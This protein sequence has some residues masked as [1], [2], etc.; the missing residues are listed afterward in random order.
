M[1]LNS[2][3]QFSCKC[4]YCC[5]LVSRLLA[6]RA[7]AALAHM[8]PAC[9]LAV[10]LPVCVVH[11]Q[12]VLVWLSINSWIELAVEHLWP[13]GRLALYSNGSPQP[14]APKQRER[15]HALSRS[16][17]WF[18]YHR[19][20]VPSALQSHVSC[21][22]VLICLCAAHCIGTLRMNSCISSLPLLQMPRTR[23]SRTGHPSLQRSCW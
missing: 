3:D 11:H 22:P 20:A 2:K 23:W 16:G 13:V 17:L 21:V 14:T 9:L 1:E 8:F 15:M 4:H 19:W 7:A 6:D 10:H 12:L 5:F 18:W